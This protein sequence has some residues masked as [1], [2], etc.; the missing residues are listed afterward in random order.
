M[1]TIPNAGDEWV[2]YQQTVANITA[3]RAPLFRPFLRR[4]HKEFIGAAL[5]CPASAS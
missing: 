1:Q 4:H 2:E 5:V 3:W